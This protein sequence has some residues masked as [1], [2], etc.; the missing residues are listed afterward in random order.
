MSGADADIE[1]VDVVDELPPPEDDGAGDERDDDRFEDGVEYQRLAAQTDEGA[2]L[3][4]QHSEIVVTG[5]PWPEVEGESQT[6]IINMGPQH[7]SRPTA[8]CAS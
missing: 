5:G 7:P 3:L 6:M 4:T 8:C 1:T 2:Q